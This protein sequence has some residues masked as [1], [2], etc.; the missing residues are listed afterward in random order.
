MEPIQ[1]RFGW[2]L[3]RGSMELVLHVLRTAA[4]SISAETGKPVPVRL[5]VVTKYDQEP[6]TSIEEF[7]KYVTPEALRKFD[8]IDL[9]AGE[10]SLW[11]QVRWSRQGPW[12]PIRIPGQAPRVPAVQLL[13]HGEGAG[14]SAETVERVALP[15]W[16][17]VNR[18]FH[19]WDVYLRSPWGLFVSWSFLFTALAFALGQLYHP[20]AGQELGGALAWTLFVVFFVAPLVI[21]IL[22]WKWLLPL[23]EI[24]PKGQSR[25]ERL[26]KGVITIVL[27]L[28]G[29]GI[30]KRLYG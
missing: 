16:G 4:A 14:V 21:L 3:W 27:G 9:T 10:R 23:V 26:R 20:V 6:F 24:A 13:V 8:W 29:A 5:I 30:A 2:G 28:I 18:G 11:V 22:G 1:R 12:L 25:L 17:A 7:Q 15:V 19:R